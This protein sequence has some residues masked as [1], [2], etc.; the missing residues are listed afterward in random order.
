MQLVTRT[1]LGWPRSSAPAQAKTKG[2]K[3]HYLGSA[4]SVG[5]LKDHSKCL[6]LWKTIRTSHL[7]N[8]REH[9]VDVAYNYAACPHGFLL[10]GRG[11]GKRTGANG[12][13]A[14]NVAHYAIVGLLGDEGLTEPT[15]AMLHAIRDGIEMLQRNGAGP[16][17]KGH[18]DGHATDCPG[19]A[20]YAW[21]QKGAPRP[22]VPEPAQESA[23][24]PMKYQPFPGAAWFRMGRKSPIVARMHDRLVAVGCGRY[25]SAVDKDVIGS[26]DVASY[27]AWQRLQGFTGSAAKWPPGKTTWDALHVPPI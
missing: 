15:A 19:E 25:K 12:N 4:V 5:L 8:I 10:E 21:V 17:I 16:E 24:A 13:Q 9:Y 22:E 3:V 20:L 27:E 11:I 1:Q 23:P 2:V 14:L 18:R 7:H 26:G 6:A